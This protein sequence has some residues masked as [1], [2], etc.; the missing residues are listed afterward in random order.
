MSINMGMIELLLYPYAMIMHD[1]KRNA[2]EWKL[3]MYFT[4]IIFRE[5]SYT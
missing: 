4:A 3:E 1:K 2:N 5:S